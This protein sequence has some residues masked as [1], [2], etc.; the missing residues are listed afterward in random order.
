MYKGIRLSYV[1]R[2]FDI[3]IFPALGMSELS[4]L[5]V[6]ALS[7]MNAKLPEF[8]QTQDFPHSNIPKLEC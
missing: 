8:Y 7:L 2:G 1:K 6:P 3:Y 4:H 5:Y